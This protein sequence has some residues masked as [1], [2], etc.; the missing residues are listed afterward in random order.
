M[1][2]QVTT[3][4]D[5]NDCASRAAA[6]VRGAEGL[7]LRLL[8]LVISAADDRRVERPEDGAV[9]RTVVRD[10]HGHSWSMDCP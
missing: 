7:T 9:S 4:P 10:R 1:V 8:V 5:V 3:R 6:C 2:A